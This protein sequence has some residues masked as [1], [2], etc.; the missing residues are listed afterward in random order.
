MTSIGSHSTSMAIN[1]KRGKAVKRLLNEYT[2]SLV[3]CS[4][5][6]TLYVLFNFLLHFHNIFY[7]YNTAGNRNS[8]VSDASCRMDMTRLEQRVYIII[9]LMRD[10]NARECLSELVEVVSFRTELSRGGRR[11]DPIE[12]H[13][14]YTTLDLQLSLYRTSLL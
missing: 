2:C 13:A 5:E 4:V 10:R 3:N 8:V 12:S 7:Y 1:G 9:A 11:G 6:H 14:F